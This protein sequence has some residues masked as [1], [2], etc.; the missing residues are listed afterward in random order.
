MEDIAKLIDNW[1]AIIKK[2]HR[3]ADENA[4]DFL[5]IQLGVSDRRGGRR[6]KLLW[7]IIPVQCDSEQTRKAILA[8][9]PLGT[10]ILHAEAIMEKEGFKCVAMH[11]RFADD[12][13]GG[14]PQLNYPPANIL[15]CDSGEHATF[16]SPIAKRWQVGFVDDDGRVARVAV[17]VGLTGP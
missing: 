17:G 3:K 1:K 11:S 16:M 2:L 10:D 4:Q 5:G 8:R 14:S 15:W 13:H 7:P 9:I 12:G 6:H